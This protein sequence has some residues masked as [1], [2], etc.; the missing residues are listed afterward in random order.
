M[1]RI[2]QKILRAHFMNRFV[3]FVMKHKD[4]VTPKLILTT[5][6]YALEQIH[7]F[8]D[9]IFWFNLNKEEP[10]KFIDVINNVFDALNVYAPKGYYFGALEGDGACFGFWPLP[11]DEEYND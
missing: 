3:Y 1:E 2:G 4:N 9:C 10:E 6:Q 7:K 11:D 8:Y 5:L